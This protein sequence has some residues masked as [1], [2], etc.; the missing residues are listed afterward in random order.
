[1]FRAGAQGLLECLDAR[2][3]AIGDV[4]G[5][6]GEVPGIEIARVETLRGFEEPL[7]VIPLLARG[8]DAAGQYVAFGVAGIESDGAVGFVERGI[9]LIEVQ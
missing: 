4:E 7:C 6:A 3:E 8:G 1:M 9:E 2:L 5:A